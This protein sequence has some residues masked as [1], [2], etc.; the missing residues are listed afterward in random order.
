MKMQL[1]LGNKTSATII[2]AYAP[3]MTNPEEVKDRFYEELDSLITSAQPGKLILLGDLNARVGT[4]HQAWHR[5]LGKKVTRK[6]NITKLKN[7]LTAQ[8]LQSRMD[9]KLLDIR[10]DQ[11]SIDEQ[12]E[13]FRDTVHSIAL[14]TLGGAFQHRAQPTSPDQRGSHRTTPPGADKPRVGCSPCSRGSEQSH[15]KNV[16]RQS[17]RL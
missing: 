15:Q 10:S 13:S 9:S 12:W 11:S 8:D 2:S 17:S 7:Q 3:T 4:D 5:V 1:P 14:K 6:L 16:H